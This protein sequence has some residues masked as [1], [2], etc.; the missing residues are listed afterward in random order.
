MD[1]HK[2]YPTIVLSTKAVSTILVRSISNSVHVDEKQTVLVATP[3]LLDGEDNQQPVSDS[4]SVCA[5]PIFNDQL[6]C[7][8]C[9]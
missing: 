7:A 1:G 8:L 2:K 9:C 6:H 3:A 5:S 4:V